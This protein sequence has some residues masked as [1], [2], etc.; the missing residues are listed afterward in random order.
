MPSWELPICLWFAQRYRWWLR[1]TRGSKLATVC[2]VWWEEW[3]RSEFAAFPKRPWDEPRPSCRVWSHRVRDSTAGTVSF[4]SPNHSFAASESCLSCSPQSMLPTVL[5]S[6]VLITWRKP[7]RSWTSQQTRSVPA[8]DVMFLLWSCHKLFFALLPVKVTVNFCTRVRA[9][10]QAVET[11]GSNGKK[12]QHCFKRLY[13]DH[14]KSSP[15]CKIKVINVVFPS[16]LKS[17]RHHSK[18]SVVVSGVCLEQD[19]WGQKSPGESLWALP[20]QQPTHREL[21]WGGGGNQ[22]WSSKRFIRQAQTGL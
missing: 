16:S 21:L 14:L 11:T 15:L 19:T 13:T 6:L 18:D 2:W 10:S 22:T 5:R 8:T 20:A 17:F 9:S 4:I 7:I 3:P 12:A 1:C